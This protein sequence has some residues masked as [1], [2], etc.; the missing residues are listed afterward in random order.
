MFGADAFGVWPDI[1]AVG[2]HERGYTPLSADLIGEKIARPMVGPGRG[3]VHVRHTYAGNRS[4]RRRRRGGA[5]AGGTRVVRTDGDGE[6]MRD[7]FRRLAEKHEVIGDVRGMGLLNGLEFVRDRETK[8]PFPEEIPSAAVERASR[9][10]G[11]LMRAAPQFVCLGPPLS[12]RPRTST[13][14]STFWMRR[15]V[16]S[17]SRC[18]KAKRRRRRAPRP[19]PS[20]RSLTP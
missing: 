20:E 9:Q 5:R 4:P 3:K 6:R 18:A 12:R 13:R 7:G 11:L 15:S 16:R 2:R 19:P 8:E 14:S 17:R 10:R 1:M